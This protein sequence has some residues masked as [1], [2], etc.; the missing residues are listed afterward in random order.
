M[1]K[2]QL[3]AILLVHFD[4]V[5][6]SCVLDECQDLAIPRLFHSGAERAAQ[7]RRPSEAAP[8]S[9]ARARAARGSRAV[10]LLSFADYSLSDTVKA[11]L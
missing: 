4:H 1:E 5:T 2:W 7:S 10:G 8:R 11:P 9:R 3:G 6:S